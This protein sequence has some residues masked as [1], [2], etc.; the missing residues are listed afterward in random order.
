MATVASIDTNITVA[1]SGLHI[2]IEGF[3]DSMLK[4]TQSLLIEISKFRVE[5]IKDQYN[6]I[7][8]EVKNNYK[9]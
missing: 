6:S 2:K 3:N 5:L 7:W 9:N 8:E 1:P 4:Y